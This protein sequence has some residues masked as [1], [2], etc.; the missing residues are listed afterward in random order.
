M[1]TAGWENPRWMKKGQEILKK[2]KMNGGRNMDVNMA[3]MDVV[4]VLTSTNGVE[5]QAALDRLVKLRG[6]LRAQPVRDKTVTERVEDLLTEIG[7]PSHLVGYRYARDYVCLLLTEQGKKMRVAQGYEMIGRD[8]RQSWKRIERGIRNAIQA[9][10]DRGDMTLLER[11]FGNT[12]DP[13]KGKPTNGEFLFRVAQIMER[14][15]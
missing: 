13:E 10:W 12:V 5:K 6:E 11:Y 15:T 2:E 4:T 8:Y 14:M 7:M 1:R 3:V 9:A